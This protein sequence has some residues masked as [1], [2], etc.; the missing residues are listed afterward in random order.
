VKW[1]GGENGVGGLGKFVRIGICRIFLSE[2]GFSG[3]AGFFLSESGFTGF[4][5][6]TGFFCQ[7]QDFQDSQELA[8]LY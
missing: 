8:G 6:L 3:L 1:R 7:N 2:S 5:R 4:T